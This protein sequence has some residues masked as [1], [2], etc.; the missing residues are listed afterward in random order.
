MNLNTDLFFVL[1]ITKSKSYSFF[2][3]PQLKKAAESYNL[4][5]VQRKYK[6]TVIHMYVATRGSNHSLLKNA[7]QWINQRPI[8]KGL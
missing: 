1:K 3:Q 8:K 5:V 2:Q 7:P 6:H 4:L